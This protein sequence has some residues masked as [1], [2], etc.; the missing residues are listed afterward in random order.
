[1][2]QL[3]AVCKVL[4][5]CLTCSAAN[6]QA[7]FAR[8]DVT[9]SEPV[10]MA[11][12][13]SRAKPSEGIDTPLHAR[14]FALK[15]ANDDQASLLISVD[16]IG[17]PGSVTRELAIAIKDSHG[18]DRERVVF[19]STHTHAGPDLISELTNIFAIPPRDDE[20]AAGKRYK[21]H[22]KASILKSVDLALKD[23]A[24]AKLA[25]AVG[26]A[27]FAANRRVLKEGRWTAFGV[28]PDGVVD[29]TVP[30]LRIT[31]EQDNVRGIVFNYA[32]HCTTIGG[33]HYRINSDWA[34]YATTNLEAKHSGA[35]ALCTIGCGADANPEP[36]GTVDAAKVHGRT[37]SAEVTRL[38]TT[39]MKPVDA[40]LQPRFD[41]AA[42]S[43]EL[44][45]GEELQARVNDPKSRPQEK[46]HAERLLGVLERAHRL[47]ATHPVPIQSWQF[48]NQLTMVFLAGEVVADYSLRL[49]DTLNNPNLWVTAYANDMPG[50]IASE[51]MIAEGGYEYFRSGVYYGLPGPWASG[52]ED[53]LIQRIE[54]LLKS[55]GRSKPLTAEEGLLSIQL[56]D[57]FEIELVAAEPLVQDPINIAFDKQGRMWVVEM[58]DYPQG[59]N[60]GKVK[61]LTDTDGDGQFDKATEFL[62][63]L[64]F[65]TGVMP[66]RDGVLV[67]AAPDILF[68]R[69]TNGDGKADDVKKIYSGFRL[70]NPQHRVSG[71]SYGLDHSLHLAAGDNLSELKSNTGVTVDASGHDVQ[72]WPDLGHIAITSG[73]TQYVRSRNDWGQWFGN[74]NSRPMYHFPIDDAYLQ[75]NEHVS[76]SGSSQQLFNPPVAP[77]VFAA[78]AATERFNDL[79]AA[80]RFTSACSA[81]VARTPTFNVADHETALLCEPVHHLVHR[82]VLEPVGP[83]FKA[84]RGPLETKSEFLA[85]S[86]PWFRPVRAMIGPDDRLY[87]V[88]MYR[89]TIEHPEWIPDA[90]QAQLDLRAGADR[91]RIYRV[92]KRNAKSEPTIDFDPSSTPELIDQL[93]SPNGALRD[94]AQQWIIERNEA[95]AIPLLTELATNANFPHARVHALSI[96]EV[97]EKLDTDVLASALED[98]HPGVLMVAISIAEKRLKSEPVLLVALEKT[99]RHNDPRV[100]LQTAL[101]LGETEQVAAADILAFIAGN[102]PDKWVA[103]AVSSSA[104]PHIDRILSVLLETPDAYAKVPGRLMSDLLVTAQ[105]SG[106]N[107]ESQYAKAFANPDTGFLS[108]LN[109]ASSL[110][111]ATRGKSSDQFTKYLRPLYTRAAELAQDEAE[112]EAH[113]CT[114]LSLVGIGIDSKAKETDFLLELLTP[115]TPQRVQ[116]QAIDRLSSFADA[117]VC[118][119]FADR[120]SSMSKSVRDHCVSMMLQRK[121]WTLQLLTALEDK[122]IPVKDISTAARRQLAHTGTRSMRVRAERVTRTTGSV[123]KQTLVRQYLAELKGDRDETK[124]AALFKQHCAVCHVPN[125]HGQAVG[126]SLNNLTDRSDHA[127][128]TAILDPNRAVDPKYQSYVVMT[129][130]QRVLVGAIESEAG[131]S[132]TL[133]H[134]DGTRTTIR[135]REIEQLKNSGVSLMPEG[136]EEVLKPEALKHLLRYLS[137]PQ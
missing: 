46:R 123:Q 80:G 102:A 118:H 35:V 81:I 64:P 91:G 127:L 44:P 87:I 77:P 134:A 11:G 57:G 15:A 126:A 26:D 20:I 78:T 8:V 29:H 63:A 50:Y 121:P 59:K 41:Y 104:L 66:W 72:I 82:A 30:V 56:S 137:K 105:A 85:S 55:R 93:R 117:E 97:L 128:V 76:F 116:L 115:R 23:L 100:V 107:F 69:D 3:I 94:L 120:W 18:I 136:L 10:R 114:A 37:L 131:Q 43:F 54:E 96:L 92:S 2:R 17:L 13:G 32:C 16:T 89:E 119:E 7:G 1:M 75:R 52:T 34:G 70:A 39:T 53:L 132:I 101:A 99:A 6:W 45:T 5:V 110:I 133:A 112:S 19:C 113:R 71:F 58:G 48:G 61:T 73:R 14:C 111:A 109:L 79:F 49:K 103:R 90:W 84:T 31:D 83:T 36:R 86:D 40:A 88:D 51:K 47:P 60:G 28:Q 24:P 27:N 98:S 122:T 124:G 68:A 130:D 108:Q 67:S 25:Y 135:R 4:L 12:Y 38:I 65:P 9:P 74:D 33:D 22:L 125:E 42:L 62:T 106:V 129:D 21:D 95:N